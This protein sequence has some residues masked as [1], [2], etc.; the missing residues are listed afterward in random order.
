MAVGEVEQQE[1][2]ALFE[3]CYALGGQEE[4]DGAGVAGAGVGG[5]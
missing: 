2:D 1:R 5:C 3:G 4:F